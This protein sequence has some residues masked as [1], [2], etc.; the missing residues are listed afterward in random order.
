MNPAFQLQRAMPVLEIADIQRSID[1][2][3][4]KLGFAVDTWGQPPTF[5]IAQRG[6]C[7]VAL[8]VLPAD[9]AK[10]SRR[11]W[12]AYLYARDVDALYAELVQHGVAIPEPPETRPY[13]C[14]EFVVDDPDGHI[15]CFGQ[16]LEPDPLGP[17]LGSRTGRD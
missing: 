2:Y 8:A 11:T 7:S 16:V 9:A 4:D 17:G 10:V 1:F 14:R 12:A 5:A 6:T 15:L 13:N 3:K